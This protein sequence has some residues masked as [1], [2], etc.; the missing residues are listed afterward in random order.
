MGAA[1]AELDR[2]DE[3]PF[4][5]LVDRL[6]LVR[7]LR[8]ADLELVAEILELVRRRR[9]GAAGHRRRRFGTRGR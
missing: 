6:A 5:R 2:E 3:A 9:A 4:W 7:E 8:D 1:A